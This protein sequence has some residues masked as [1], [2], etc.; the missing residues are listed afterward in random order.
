[1]LSQ[2]YEA[3]QKQLEAEAITLQQKI[4]VQERQTKTLKSSFRK[5]TSMSALKNWTA[6]LCGSWCPLS[7][8]MRRTSPAENGYSTSISSTTG[9]ALS[10]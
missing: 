10:L 7:M 5:R 6:M 2:T 1:M 9:W 3:E 4:E 8:W